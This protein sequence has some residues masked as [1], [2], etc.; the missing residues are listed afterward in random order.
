MNDERWYFN[1]VDATTGGYLEAPMSP[2]DVLEMLRSRPWRPE[3]KAMVPGFEARS[4]TESGWG[5]V[6]PRGPEGVDPALRE[7]LR[8]LLDHRQE[9]AAACKEIRYRELELRRGEDLDGFLVRHGRGPGPVH[10]DRLPYYLLL[11]GD[12]AALPF[13]FQ[14]GLD[15]QHAVG[16]LCFDTLEDYHAY[17]CAVVRAETEGGGRDRLLDL[18]AP[19]HPDDPATELSSDHLIAPLAER[20]EGDLEGWRLRRTFGEDA[21]R[22]A[23]SGLFEGVAGRPAL[24]FTASHGTGFPCGHPD[25][26]ER[27]G[28]LLCQDW[29]GPVESRGPTPPEW[30]FAAADLSA[31]ADVA[32]LIAFCFACYGAGTPA[33]DD[34]THRN[35]WKPRQLAPQDFVARL[36]QRLLARGALAVIGHLERAW[37]QSFLWQGTAQVDVFESVLKLLLDGWPVGGAMEYFNQRYAELATRLTTELNRTLTGATVDAREVTRLWTAHNDARGYVVAGDPAVRV[38][39]TR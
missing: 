35:D 24:L 29:P 19:R 4:L 23:L 20:L 2:G 12:P 17:A 21:T 33:Q 34:Y 32:G 36:P 9:Q 38:N 26:R 39:V 18:F 3:A 7:A 25:Q 8:P 28:A 16:R 13:G 37:S 30:S 1:G 11:V 22:Q 6:F 5:A 31:R 10:P 14:T 15:V 27:Q